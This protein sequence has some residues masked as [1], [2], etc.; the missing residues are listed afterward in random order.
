MLLSCNLGDVD[1]FCFMTCGVVAV[2][3]RLYQR[4]PYCWFGLGWACAKYSA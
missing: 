1:E 3:Q 4:A 2:I